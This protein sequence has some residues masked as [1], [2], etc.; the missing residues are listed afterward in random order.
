MSAY[1]PEAIV[2][3]VQYLVMLDA[4][5]PFARPAATLETAE[6]ELSAVNAMLTEMSLVAD[7]SAVLA[8]PVYGAGVM[9]G[10]DDVGELLGK[11]PVNRSK[12]ICF[13]G[14]LQCWDCRRYVVVC[15]QLT[16]GGDWSCYRK[17]AANRAWQA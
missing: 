11:H 8:S 10:R 9:V 7:G 5:K 3:A 12:A 15:H 16:V 13:R 6:G 14:G 2:S 17:T 1:E 4:L